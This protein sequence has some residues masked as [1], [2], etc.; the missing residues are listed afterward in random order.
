MYVGIKTYFRIRLGC[1][2]CE[3]PSFVWND[4]Q[5]LEKYISIKEEEKEETIRKGVEKEEKR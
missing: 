3:F 5:R 1:E 4:K 2:G